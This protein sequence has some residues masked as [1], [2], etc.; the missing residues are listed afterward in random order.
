MREGICLLYWI[1]WLFLGSVQ[2]LAQ[3]AFYTFMMHDGVSGE[4]QIYYQSKKGQLRID[5]LELDGCQEFV[6][7][8]KGNTYSEFLVDYSKDNTRN[9]LFYPSEVLNWPSGTKIYSIALVYQIFEN[10]GIQ[11]SLG[12]LR[13]SLGEVNDEEIPEDSFVE[14]LKPYYDGPDLLN[15]SSMNDQVISYTFSEPYVYKGG[16]LVVD[17]LSTTREVTNVNVY[18]GSCR[19]Q[20]PYI[21]N[22]NSN[23]EHVYQSSTK[24]D[25]TFMVEFS[26]EIPIPYISFDERNVICGYSQIGSSSEVV[27]VTVE[28]KGS[29]DLI[30]SS[31]KNSANFRLIGEKTIAP[32]SVAEVG[33]EFVPGSEGTF[34]EEA[35]LVTNGGDLVLKLTGTTYRQAPYAY[36]VE[37]RTVNQLRNLLYDKK[38]QIT[39]LSVM[40]VLGYGDLD[41]FGEMPNLRK[42][43]LSTA[44]CLEESWHNA[45]RIVSHLEQ[46]ALP[47]GMTYIDLEGM[48]NLTKLA[49]PVGYEDI[50]E[51]V[52]A[53]LTSLIFL[54][55]D[56]VTVSNLSYI[57][58]IETIY[59]PENVIQNW[60]RDYYWQ[61][62]EI[63]PITDE[64]LGGD[65]SGNIVIRGEMEYTSDNYPLNEVEISMKP[66][67]GEEGITTVGLINKA[68]IRMN[69]LSM[70]YNLGQRNSNEVDEMFEENSAYSSFI[71]ENSDVLLGTVNYDLSLEP[72]RWYFISFPFDVNRQDLKSTANPAEYVIRYYDAERRASEGSGY[73]LNWK[74]VALDGILKAGQGY[75]IQRDYY[76]TTYPDTDQFT[77]SLSSSSETEVQSMLNNQLVSLTLN[78]LPSEYTNNANWNFVGNPYPSFFDIHAINYNAPI[79]IWNGRGYNALSLTDDSYVLRPLE[80]FFTQKPDETHSME[81]HPEGRR[82]NAST[83]SLRAMSDPNRELLNLSLVGEDY[84][85]RTRI[86]INPRALMKQELTCD[87]VKWMSPNPEVPQIYSLG[88]EDL[89][90]AI[91]ERPEGTGRIAIGFYAG[92]AGCYTISL[93]STS[94]AVYLLDKYENRQ[95]DLSREKY[96]FVAESGTFDDRF[97]LRLSGT[98]T[99]ES[100]SIDT[101]RVWTNQQRLW[102]EAPTGSVIQIYSVAGSLVREGYLNNGLFSL[103]LPDGFYLVRVNETTHKVT[104]H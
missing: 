14:Q 40:G 38:E 26:E 61:N 48:E 22:L 24:P 4:K 86:V 91:N 65:F 53:S 101:V 75:I 94:R 84:V 55:L 103:N 89:R 97:E 39:E 15:L 95:V 83:S 72:N 31:L 49:L 82:L 44:K 6:I 63:L 100:L 36:E 29:S 93:E 50:R 19:N 98:T 2:L 57:E 78:S 17:F 60:Q 37:N 32:H 54:G 18:T 42:L 27:Y 47:L 3:D 9:Q 33:F 8:G 79:I 1:S 85:D 67:R 56:P 70:S 99:N 92:V 58:H 7:A 104:I 12:D 51:K 90:Y 16:C 88:S 21:Y 80:A 73:D 102:V 23:G 74:D 71:N 5:N 45:S 96:Y 20:L 43:D 46:L 69:S 30:V 68:P 11:E 52:P 25:M 59:V 81:F 10:D 41:F 35:V 62:K 76:P 28:N 64:I 87:A 66:S 77:L 34:E 13:I